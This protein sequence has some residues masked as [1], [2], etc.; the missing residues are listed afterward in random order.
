MLG[1]G[2]QKI[3]IVVGADTAM[4]ETK[5]GALKSKLGALSKM[6]AVATVAAAAAKV[7]ASIK[8]FSDFEQAMANV[9]SVTFATNEEFEKLKSLAMSD[10]VTQLGYSAKEAADAMYYL[11]SAGYDAT[12]AGAALSGVLKLAAASQSDLALVAEKTAAAI[13]MFGLEASDADMVADKFAYTIANSQATMEK[14]ADSMTYAGPLFSQLGYNI[15][16]MLAAL[17]GLYNLGIPASQAGTALRQALSSLADPTA[18]AAAVLDKFGLT[19]ADISPETNTFG[20]ILATLGQAGLS[21]SDMIQVL[22][23]RGM[24]MG[25]MAEDAGAGFMEFK[26]GLENAGGTAQKMADIQMDTLSGAFKVL[27]NSVVNSLISFG[28][29]M[30]GTLGLSDRLR[31]LAGFVTSFRDSLSDAFDTG[32]AKGFGRT[33]SRA[34]LDIPAKLLDKFQQL[35]FGAAFSGASGFLAGAVSGLTDALNGYDWSSLGGKV[36]EALKGAGE[37]LYN[38]VFGID[39]AG[40]AGGIITAFSGLGQGIYDE[41]RDTDWRGAWDTL[42]LELSTIGNT[43]YDAF[44]N[45]SQEDIT[46]AFTQLFNGV[47]DGLSFVSTLA[48]K[49]ADWVVESIQWVTQYIKSGQMVADFQKWVEGISMALRNTMTSEESQQGFIDAIKG[50]IE[51]IGEITVNIAKLIV[52]FAKIVPQLSLSLL[53]SEVGKAM[54]NEI[55]RNLTLSVAVKAVAESINTNGLWNTISNALNPFGLNIDIPGFAT[56]GIVTSP[57]MAMIGE[58]GPEAVVPLDRYNQLVS[59]NTNND[60]SIQNVEIVNNFHIS[61]KLDK[62]EVGRWMSYIDEQ[63]KG[64]KS[65]R[66]GLYFGSGV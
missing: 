14:L 41:L 44:T 28:D 30:V 43:V 32:D 49:M 51:S 5:L 42:K 11:G 33:I 1:Y 39:W 22:N 18:N 36:G 7:G 58:A 24:S 20:E 19:V 37:F 66:K 16:D 60:N 52:E 3:K 31:D 53:N 45:I 40:L 13:T 48:G 38:A 23:L 56:G 57:T 61:Q 54:P 26:E 12:Q 59:G 25:K 63:L 2:D 47:L 4:A 46:N 65:K 35:D 15:D 10:E 64:L 29:W 9:K 34:I 50:A 55:K 6:A 21:T 27:K 62:A 8:V 17:G